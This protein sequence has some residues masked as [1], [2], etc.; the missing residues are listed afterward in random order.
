MEI[1]EDFYTIVLS[2]VKRHLPLARVAPGLR[3]ALFN[4]LGDTEIVKAVTPDLAAMIPDD[5]EV[6][7]HPEGKGI[8]L[9]CELASYTGLPYVVPRKTQKQWMLDPISTDVKSITT[10]KDE[11]Y[12]LDR[13][14]LHRIEGK[15]VAIVD[16]VI[17]TGS[18]LTA[19]ENLVA[20]TGGTV[21]ARV[22][23]LT[24]GDEREDVGTLGHLPL[25]PDE[26]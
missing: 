7:L 26:E 23:I 18:T 16:D 3:V 19:M 9:V 11:K 20:Q 8:P 1:K 13:R 25:F 17:S 6:L 14:E 5:A 15:K 2:G 12:W 4:I 22:A 10:G 24:E 21:V